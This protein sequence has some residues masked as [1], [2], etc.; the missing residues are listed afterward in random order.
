[1][2]TISHEDDRKDDGGA[3]M[4]LLNQAALL[5]GALRH[6]QFLR[7]LHAKGVTLQKPSAQSIH[8]YLNLWLP[9]VATNQ[10]AV[11]I[12]PPDIAWLWRKSC[13]CASVLK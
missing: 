5:D 11:T 7:K 2:A 13:C 10:D 1:M 8:R 6:I 9:L 3:D 12:P 4:M